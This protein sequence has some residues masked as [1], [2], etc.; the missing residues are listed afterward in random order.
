MPIAEATL[1]RLSIE[2]AFPSPQSRMSLLWSSVP[3]TAKHH[4]LDAKSIGR[5]M[6]GMARQS[7]GISTA[8]PRVERSTEQ[9]MALRQ[10]AYRILEMVG[11]EQM[12]DHTRCGTPIEGTVAMAGGNEAGAGIKHLVLHMA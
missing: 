5:A 7:L 12:V 1:R 10:T 2:V 11:G 4:A 8:N 6:L 3:W 9:T